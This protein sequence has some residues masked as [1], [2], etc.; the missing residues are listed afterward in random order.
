MSRT[1]L[2]CGFALLAAF[3]MFVVGCSSALDGAPKI[4]AMLGEHPADWM[5]SH[6][7]DFLAK[8]AECVTCHG[9]Y[10]EAANAG[11]ISRLSCFSCH[12]GGV[13]H[14]SGYAERIAHGRGGAQINPD[15]TSASPDPTPDPTPMAGFASCKKCHGDDYRG[16][17]MAVSCMGCHKRAPHPNRPWTGV[18]RDWIRV[19]S[20]YQTHEG[21]AAAC[22][23][24]H[25]GGANSSRPPAGPPAP[26]ALPGCYNNTLCHAYDI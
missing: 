22:A 9:S 26:G 15:Q 20:H 12:P 17:G 18:D 21:N 19:P 2:I 1:K 8:P 14:E 25:A 24:C 6:G 11:G 23:Q 7:S 13:T 10:R 3:A 16:H 5:A 4:D